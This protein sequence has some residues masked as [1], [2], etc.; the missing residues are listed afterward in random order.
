M[1]SEPDIPRGDPRRAADTGPAPDRAGTGGGRDGRAAADGW[2][3]GGGANGNSDGHGSAVLVIPAVGSMT[4]PT[5]PTAAA[6]PEAGQADAAPRPETSSLSQPAPPPQRGW[7]LPLAVLIIG[8]FMS[9]L[10]TTI[11]NIAIT[12]IRRDF[13]ATIEHAQWISTAYALTEGAIVP[14]SAWMG[15]RLGYKQLYV[16]SIG[17]FTLFSAACGLSTSLNEMIIFRILQ[18]IPGGMIPVMCITLIYRMVPREKIGAAMGLYGLGVTVAPGVGPT[19][20]GYF[21]EYL[22]WPWI[23]WVNVPI[24]AAATFAALAVLPRE[25]GQRGRPF[26]T[27][28]FACIV[29]GLFAVLLACEQGTTWG[30]TGYRVLGLLALGTNL[31]LLW[32]VVE[33]Q[34]EH[35]LLDVRVFKNATFVKSALLIGALF[36]GLFAMLFNLPQFLQ[37]VQGL[38]P[39]HTGLI[40][41]PQA[42]VLMV[43]M[44]MAGQLYDRIG[45]RWPA[46]AG[47][48]LCGGGLLLLSRINT[49]MPRGDIILAEC[50]VSAGMGI[51]MIPIMTG[52][53]DALTGPLGEFGSAFNT[54]VQRVSQSFGTALLTALIIFN[55][56]QFFSDRSA[57]IDGRGANAD[58]HI[59]QMGKGGPGGLIGYWQQ[60]N[61]QTQTLAYSQAFLVAGALVLVSA[62]V[63]VTLPAGRPNAGG[64]KPVAH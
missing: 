29:V 5:E 31:L 33:L 56:G 38:T 16:W 44:P 46:V 25:Q 35:P 50:V 34:V 22:S 32:V 18:A 12:S 21:V 27:L 39:S 43:L 2:P 24:G 40:L 51:C 23:Y 37:G 1:T 63:A 60:I 8:M 13:G 17:L 7:G 62:L 64:D 30:W 45:S 49:D 3:G 55:G 4:A 59:T 10:D 58:P 6:P 42:L 26:D 53:L 41:L 28:G 54:L 47:M 36:V 57:I 15:A 11:V 19:L 9:I 14:V 48:A 61:N 20:G 52:G